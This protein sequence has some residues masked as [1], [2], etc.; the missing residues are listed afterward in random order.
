MKYL[1]SVL[2]LLFVFVPEVNAAKECKLSWDAS[3]SAPP[4][5]Y[6]A[7]QNGEVFALT[8]LLTVTTP[9]VGGDTFFVTAI[10][11]DN[12]ESDPTRTLEVTKKPLNPILTR[13]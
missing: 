4:I 10:N 8:E 5:N 7:Y 2:F 3:E 12:I 9:C 1:L 13:K 6:N 11:Q